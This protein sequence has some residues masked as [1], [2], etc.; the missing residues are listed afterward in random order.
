MKNGYIAFSSL[1]V[2]SAVVLAIAVSVS[3]MG[4][5][6]IKNSFA[7]SQGEKAEA[8]T[9]ACLEEALY[10]LRD[11]ADYTSGTLNI[12]TNL[13][14]TI[15]VSGSAANRTI[16]ITATLIGPP[17]YQKNLTLT[18]KRTGGGINLLTWTEN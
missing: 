3:L 5:D 14:C 15:S 18:V 10:R 4:I 6:E 12:D 1:L 2:I 8:A 7:L 13:N 9:K 11:D 16:A 17:D